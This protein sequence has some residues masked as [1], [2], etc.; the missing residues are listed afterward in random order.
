MRSHIRGLL[1]LGTP[2]WQRGI[3][4]STP[5]HK[6]PFFPPVS[7]SGDGRKERPPQWHNY[8]QVYSIVVYLFY[9]TDDAL[10]T[11]TNG[12]TAHGFA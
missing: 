7:L 2:R 3:F 9:E 6:K 12:K 4:P 1:P 8:W 10:E 11:D 5:L